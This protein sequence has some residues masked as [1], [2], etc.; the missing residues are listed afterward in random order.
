MTDIESQ[1][2]TVDAYSE[3]DIDSNTSEKIAEVRISGDIDAKFN[4]FKSLISLLKRQPYDVRSSQNSFF[5]PKGIDEQLF[6]LRAKIRINRDNNYNLAVERDQALM[7]KLQLEQEIYK[8]FSY[9]A[10]N[11]TDTTV[12]ELEDKLLAEKKMLSL[13]DMKAYKLRFAE[14]QNSEEGSISEAL[15]VNIAEI[16]MHYHFYQEF[17]A[18]L[19]HNP[20]VLHYESLLN[21]LRLGPIVA[22]INASSFAIDM[23]SYLR[24]IKLDLGRISLFMLLLILAWVIAKLHYDQLYNF[25]R[26]MIIK[27]EHLS[28]QMHLSNLEYLRKPIMILIYVFA[29]DLGIDI[30]LYP[31]IE[32][33]G[34]VFYL[35]YLSLFSY[36]LVTIIDN[37]VYHYLLK[38]AEV[39]EKQMR[40]ELINLIISIVKS[41]VF[42]IAGILFLVQ[43]GVNITGLLASLGIGGLAVALAAKDTLS[44]FFG[45]LKILSDNSFSQGDWIQ[46]DDIDG[47]VVEIGFVSTAIRTFDNALISVPN[48]KLAN[49][50]LKNWNRRQVG[51]R[52]KM[53]IGVTYGSDRQK[54]T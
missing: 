50:A 6:K 48:E 23:N 18:Y 13:I 20:R 24:Y 21:Q 30:L 14:T 43:I 15:H 52:I 35:L 38:R 7:D 41:V 36:I 25:L 4:A 33:D 37:F 19:I 47:T 46:T 32:R 40:H 29:V 42:I 3:I 53:H 26:N 27:K 45:L 39:K 2:F 11:W 54:L 10:S 31:N 8:F 49:A 28:D 5:D 17:L 9:L 34:I 51:R 1:F 12:Q 44:N 22:A 16:M